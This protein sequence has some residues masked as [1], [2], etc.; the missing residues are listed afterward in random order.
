M[1]LGLSN[2]SRLLIRCLPPLVNELITDLIALTLY[3]P[4]SLLAVFLDAVA[5]PVAT[6]PL[7]YYCN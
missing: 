6:F 3:Y 7:S 2:G 1:L 5:L 4:V